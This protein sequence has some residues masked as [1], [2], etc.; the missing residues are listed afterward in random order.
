MLD[1]GRRAGERGRARARAHGEAARRRASPPTRSSTSVRTA[2]RQRAL[3]A[4]TPRRRSSA[5]P[6]A[7]CATRA[8]ARPSPAWSRAATSREGEFVAPG[9]EALRP[10]RA[11]PDR[12]RVPPGRARLE[13]RRGR[14][15]ASRC[16]SR[17]SRTRSSAPTVTMV[18]P[19]H[20]PGHAHA[21]R[22]GARSTNADGPAA[23]GPLRARRP[24]RRGARGRADD[25]RGGGAAA[26]RR[27]GRVPRRA[28]ATASSAAQVELGVIRDG[29]VEVR[30][31][32]RG[33]RPG[34]GA[35]P[36]ASW[37]TASSVVGARRRRRDARRPP[38]ERRRGA[39]ARAG[40]DAVTLSDVSIQRPILTWMMT[41]ALLVFGVLGYQ[42]LGV[43]QFPN[44]EFPVLTVMATLEGADARGHGGG[45][46]RRPRGAAQHDRA[47]CARSARRRTRASTLI[48]V[49]FELGTDLDVAAQDVRDKVG[50]GA[51][52]PA[53]RR[54]IRR[55]SA[56][57]D[58]ERHA[59]PVDPVRQPS[60]PS[61]E[62]SEYVRRQIK[63]FLET[64]PGV[65]GVAMFGRHDRNIRIWLDGDA[66]RARGLSAG[67][68]AGGAA[69][70][71]RRG[72]GRLGRGRP[73]RVRRSRPTP[74]SARVAELERLVVAHAGRRAG[75]ACATWRASRT[76]PRTRAPSHATTAS[77]PSASASASSRAATPSRS[78]TRCVKRL[79]D[80]RE[81]AARRASDAPRRA[82]FIDFSR[83]DP[84]GGR[85]DAV[86]AG[87]SARC[88]P[89]SRCSCSCAARAR[90]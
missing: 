70:R 88:S 68:R 43:D 73:R 14:A 72:A 50:A 39:G 36:G 59:D 30:S 63:P 9:A 8:C 60:C 13:P 78:S 34:R 57:F 49:E 58:S 22:E 21:A 35:R 77:P 48:T 23:A 81:G 40:R 66:L 89:C 80:D 46:H 24:R 12:G 7:R 53:R 37:S 79:G 28:T 52:R 11:R 33:R 17:R 74:S 31:G 90:R 1:A 87:R 42:R 64:I 51:R 25:P 84:R 86:H 47:A 75:A 69:A 10:G 6:S 71:A 16:A 29:R 18:S 54:S 62:T 56:T 38:T 32:P 41:L 65:A 2:L 76:A 15:T 3:A 82:G 20:R 83:G 4:A 67:R 19:T 55:S 45:R 5:W 85:R 61:V 26:R 44:M 27:L